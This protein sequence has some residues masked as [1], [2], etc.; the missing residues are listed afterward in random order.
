MKLTHF[1]LKILALC[2]AVAAVVCT[3]MAYWDRIND[4]FGF[5]KDALEERGCCRRSS[6]Y[7]D[8]A[9]WDE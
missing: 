7:D 6:E 4:F 3:V 5:V 8:Y 9:E 2:F 1:L